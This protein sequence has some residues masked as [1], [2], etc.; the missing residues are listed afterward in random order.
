MTTQAFTFSFVGIEGLATISGRV[1][2]ACAGVLADHY[3]LVRACLAAHGGEKV[4]SR[5]AEFAAGLGGRH[6]LKQGGRPEQIFQLRAKSLLAAF[7]P[8]RSLAARCR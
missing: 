7:P 5:D 8:Q 6:R 4:V 2:D 3:R 1:G